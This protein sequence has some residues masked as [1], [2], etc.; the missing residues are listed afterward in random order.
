MAQENFKNDES[1]C[2]LSVAEY[3]KSKMLKI[4][5][6]DKDEDGNYKV[7]KIV[8]DVDKLVGKGNVNKVSKITCDVFQVAVGKFKGDDGKEILC[9]GNLMG[10][11]GGNSG[12]D[13]KK[14]ITFGGEFKQEEWNWN[15]E[16]LKFEGK[17]LLPSN[18]YVNGCEESTFVFMRWQIPNQAD[19]Y[20]DN[21]T[22]WDESGK[23]IPLVK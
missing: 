5:V 6:L 23:S 11:F 13:G 20:M 16:Y 15:W 3:N 21:I 4:E 8:F 7:P 17:I 14:W 18:K 19:I 9:P 1:N 10:L 2:N 22:F 12:S